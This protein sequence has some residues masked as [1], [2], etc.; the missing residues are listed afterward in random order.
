MFGGDDVR[1]DVWSLLDDGTFVGAYSIEHISSSRGAWVEEGRVT[2]EWR[3]EGE[4]LCINAR[5]DG[6]TEQAC[7]SLRKRWSAA[8]S[9]EFQ[10]TESG[11]N[12]P[13][14]FHVAPGR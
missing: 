13:W 5:I 11:N 12:R 6:Y 4:R 14:M 2:G 10:A 7:F 3:I 8:S 9:T 1:Y